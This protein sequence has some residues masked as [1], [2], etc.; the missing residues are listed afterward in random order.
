MPEVDNLKKQNE[1][2]NLIID[3]FNKEEIKALCFKMG[4][5][6][7]NFPENKSGMA[8]ELVA[9]CRRQG[10]LNDLERAIGEK[11][12]NYSDSFSQ[13]TRRDDNQGQVR[14]NETVTNSVLKRDR[15][16]P[17]KKF[18]SVASVLILI[19]GVIADLFGVWDGVKKI[20]IDEAEST[21]PTILSTEIET[22][23]SD[24]E[25]INPTLS[26][27]TPTVVL[28]TPNASAAIPTPIEQ[29]TDSTQN[30]VPI[31]MVNN[32]Y[33]FVQVP[34]GTFQINSADYF[35][36]EFWI[37]KYEI[38]NEQFVTFLNQ[39]KPTNSCFNDRPCLDYPSPNL[40]IYLD[41][42]IWRA[43]EEEKDHPVVEVTYEG[44]RE[45]CQKVFE[46]GDLPNYFQ[47]VKAA[48]WHPETNETTTFP[49]GNDQPDQF[50]A[51]FDKNNDGTVPVNSFPPG[52]SVVGAFNM[53]GNVWEFVAV[54]SNSLL[55]WMGGGWR[56]PKGSINVFS[57][58]SGSIV[59][60]D[61]IGFRCASEE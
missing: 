56:S 55:R 5:D 22:P 47:W 44:A 27:N 28:T 41:D 16:L 61:D 60:E 7:E 50:V 49:W 48:S 57:A 12:S 35:V 52:Q 59:S 13:V 29:P 32:G 23:S 18:I 54:Q 42:G 40:A 8:R 6:Y 58:D 37:G 30:F 21:T 34:S 33:V 26:I 10:R 3:R 15:N 25:Q 20:F 51:N 45:F 43:V 24:F 36:E 11:S 14:K 31:T 39:V 38:T 19:L 1:L 53:S 46:N 4:I 9:Y 2:L 17:G